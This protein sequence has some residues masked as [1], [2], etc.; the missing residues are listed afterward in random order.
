MQAGKK[1]VLLKDAFLSF[2]LAL[3]FHFKPSTPNFSNQTNTQWF[4]TPC[5]YKGHFVWKSTKPLLYFLSF[6]VEW[7][8]TWSQTHLWSGGFNLTG[9]LWDTMDTANMYRWSSYDLWYFLT[10]SQPQNYEPLLIESLF[11][12]IDCMINSGWSC[13]DITQELLGALLFGSLQFCTM[14]IL[15]FGDRREKFWCKGFD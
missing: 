5:H 3:H 11:S 2:H 8:F 14:A 13:C 6:I 1:K 15:F 12:T 9:K 7:W 4:C 10:L